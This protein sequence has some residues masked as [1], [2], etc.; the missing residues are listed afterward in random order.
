MIALALLGHLSRGEGEGRDE[1]V[2]GKYVV[3]GLR[4]LKTKC[5][6]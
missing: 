1:I 3:A 2:G 4:A 5:P 6:G